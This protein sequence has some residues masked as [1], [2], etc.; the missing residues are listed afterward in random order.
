[1]FGDKDLDITFKEGETYYTVDSFNRKPLIIEAEC[2]RLDPEEYNWP[3]GL[4]EKKVLFG[5]NYPT[6]RY[7]HPEDVASVYFSS[8]ERK[9]ILN[10]YFFKDLNEAVKRAIYVTF[11]GSE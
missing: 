8:S 10:N 9:K 5:R 11:E 2:H 4:Y 1:M 7:T 3:Y 6:G